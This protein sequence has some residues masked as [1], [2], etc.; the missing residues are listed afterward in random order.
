MRETRA[1]LPLDRHV[2][3]NAAFIHAN[4]AGVNSSAF[5]HPSKNGSTGAS[6]RVA[7]GRPPARFQHWPPL[8]AAGHVCSMEHESVAVE[9]LRGPIDA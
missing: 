4:H 1:S 2:S 6:S 9:T 5:D 3:P 7:G 8:D